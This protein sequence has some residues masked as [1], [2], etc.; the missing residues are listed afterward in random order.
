MHTL[1][2]LGRLFWAHFLVEDF[3]IDVPK[4]LFHRGPNAVDFL[5]VQADGVLA[6]LSPALHFFAQWVIDL[7]G[8]VCQWK[9]ACQ[10]VGEQLRKISC[11]QPG[12]EFLGCGL[13]RAVFVHPDAEIWVYRDVAG[14]PRVFDRR[15]ENAQIDGFFVSKAGTAQK[16]DV[17]RA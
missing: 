9:V 5:G 6:C 2:V 8:V 3:D 7:D 1:N 10:G 4:F 11:T 16:V 13:M 17:P 15:L 12:H 14:L